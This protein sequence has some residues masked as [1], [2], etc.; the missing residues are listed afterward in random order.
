[1]GSRPCAPG[2]ILCVQ[3]HFWWIIAEDHAAHNFH[4][5]SGDGMGLLL[6]AIQI[7]IYL[8]LTHSEGVGA[9]G[10]Q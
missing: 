2:V 8:Q 5:G 10:I 4:T 9:V 6:Q 1:M 3:R 7:T